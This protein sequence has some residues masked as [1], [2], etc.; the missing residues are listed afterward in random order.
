MAILTT[1]IRTGAVRGL[2]TAVPGITVF[3]GIPFAKAPAGELRWKAPVAPEAWEGE[4][5]CDDFGYSCWQRNNNDSPMFKKMQE[6]NPVPPRPLRMDEDCLSLNVWTPAV[7]ADERLPV[8]VWFYG[9][10]LHSGTSDDII[11][12]G[13]AL[14]KFGVLL[15]TVNYRVNVFGY[16]GHPDLEKEN[17]HHSSGNYGLQDQIFALQWIHDNIA[18]FGG[19]AGS[20]TIFGCSGGGRSVQGISC[21]PLSRGLVHHAVCHSAGGLNPNYSLAYDKIKELGVEFV[22]YCGKKTI[23]EMR[24]IPAQELEEK[25][26]QFGKQFN[27]TGDG[28]ALPYTMDEVVRRG[29]QADLDYL[30]CTMNDE[31]IMPPR[32]PVTLA[33]FDEMRP[34]F[35]LRTS[36]L[37]QVV[38]PRTDEEAYDVV[39]RAEAYEMKAAQLA[40]AQ[41]QAKQPKKPV[42]LSTFVHP[43]PSHDDGSARHGDDQYYVFHTMYKFAHPYGEKDEAVSQRLMRYW[44]NFAKTGDP[45]GEGLPAWT[46]Y[47]QDSPLTL[48]IDT[49]DCRMEDRSHPIIEEV[50]ATY[51]DYKA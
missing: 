14:C 40:W 45:N 16:F 47:T 26:I 50:A 15:V 28:Y 44:T 37:G 22:A 18:A 8:M 25:Y 13:E 34:T 27:I 23:D 24:A 41:V 48:T 49:D 21:S 51:R 42:R 6:I 30:L 20:V 35:G 5:L 10:N 33:N 31:F 29:E 1:T 46:P 17:E 7:S 11:F 19:D 2:E 38:H 12:D 36:I 3:K 4:R 39:A 43:V 9:G 32:Q